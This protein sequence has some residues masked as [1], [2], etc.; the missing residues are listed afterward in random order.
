P[1]DEAF[2]DSPRPGVFEIDLEAEFRIVDVGEPGFVVGIG[3]H[4]ASD[5]LAG[6][7]TVW[8]SRALDAHDGGAVYRQRAR[9]VGPDE[10]PAEARHLYARERLPPGRVPILLV[11]ALRGLG[12]WRHAGRLAHEHVVLSDRRRG[13]LEVV[14]GFACQEEV[15]RAP[16][17]LRALRKGHLRP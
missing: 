4:R 17:R 16:H 3:S 7:D 10:L 15:P 1:G 9:R 5:V 12:G 14:V 8:P 13:P 11:R 2:D 6:T